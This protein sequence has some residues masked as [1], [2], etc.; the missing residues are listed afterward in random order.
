M[1]AFRLF[2]SRPARRITRAFAATCALVVGPSFAVVAQTTALVL[3]SQQGDPI[4][5]GVTRI[6][7]STDGTFDVSN[8]GPSGVFIT[9]DDAEAHDWFL[10]FL[11]PVATPLTTG[12]Y[13]NATRIQSPVGSGLNVFGEGRGC[14]QSRGRFEV[15]EI[16][17]GPN[18]EI[19]RFAATFEQHCEDAARALTGA[20]L[21]NST[22]PVPAPPPTT[23][24]SRSATIERLSQEV[25]EIQA[26][27]TPIVKLNSLLDEAQSNVDANRPWLARSI[28]GRFVSS[29]VHY[30]NLSPTHRNFVSAPEADGLLCG[31]SNVMTNLLAEDSEAMDP[32]EPTAATLS[33][34]LELVS[35]PG[36]Y[37]GNGITQVFGPNDG[38]FTAQRFGDL[39]QIDFDGGPHRWTLRFA[40][41]DFGPLALGEYTG[42]ARFSTPTAAGLDVSGEGRGCNE[43]TGRFE[44]LELG[45][46][47]DGSVE[48]FAAT[49]EQ[50]C[51]QAPPDRILRGSIL[52]NSTLPPPHMPTLCSS[53]IASVP[54]LVQEIRELPVDRRRRHVL[55]TLL[56]EAQSNVDAMRP[57]RARSVLT[58]FIGT[59]VRSSNLRAEDPGY[60]TKI[61]ADR[62]V[63]GASNLMTNIHP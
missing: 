37:I 40:G 51:E 35:P 47:A 15:L 43:S 13:E 60:I 1:F 18:G 32:I 10:T 6:F 61:E 39:V 56:L 7:Q 42:T 58:Q 24:H 11:G 36:E 25:S 4:G 9:F 52:L 27:A 19:D 14:N 12:I 57:R 21:L 26:G 49:F 28:L 34:A 41:P 8:A 59:V 3:A 44:I 54:G 2:R 33:D 5:E 46:G 16:T 17:Y 45:Y 63:C 23:C 20:V 48:N 55:R 62:L 29:A 53:K 38:A 30:S 22:L 31:A 50:A